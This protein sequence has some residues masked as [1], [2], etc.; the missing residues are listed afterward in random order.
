M[1]E[2]RTPLL[3]TVLLWVLLEL[4]AATQVRSPDGLPLAWVWVRAAVAPA[5]W[6]AEQTGR[7]IS[8]L[9]SGVRTTRQLLADNQ[10]LRRDLGQARMRIVLLEEDRAAL[11]D[12][13]ELVDRVAEFEASSIPARC[14]YRNSRLG[15]AEVRIEGAAVIPAD[16]PV[17]GAG[18]LVGRVIRTS[19]QRCWVE[20]ITHP[21]AAVAVQTRD[22]TVHGLAT[23][24]GGGEVTVEYVPRTAPLLRGS[25]LVTS[26][27][28]GIYPPGIP[29][30]EV[31]RIRETEAAFL[32]VAAT[33]TAAIA[34]ARVV[35]LLP[36]FRGSGEGSGSR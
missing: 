12:A 36:D 18:G 10:R 6:T 1:T 19:R 22:G 7:L 8:D 23:G 15:R 9:L 17:V 26:G 14:V 32:Q 11:R 30:V 16:T 28:D 20:L 33:P 5:R 34:T 2:H 35:L 21:A 24:T 27:A 29:V 3:R 4:L 31:T 13:A 25:V